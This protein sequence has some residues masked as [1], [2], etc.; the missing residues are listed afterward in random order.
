MHSLPNSMK[1]RWHRK[2]RHLDTKE[3]NM[4]HLDEES[5]AISKEGNRT[6]CLGGSFISANSGGKLR[7]VAEDNIKMSAKKS[8]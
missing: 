7:I 1:G 8:S 6:V 2:S 3:G 4:L 5:I